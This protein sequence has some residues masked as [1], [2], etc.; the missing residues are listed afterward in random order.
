VRGVE[1]PVAE[2]LEDCL[3]RL[4]V[5]GVSGCLTRYPLWAAEL[6]PL[7]RMAARLQASAPLQMRPAARAALK[8]QV[9]ARATQARPRS[10]P[11]GLGPRLRRWLPAAPLWRVAVAFTLILALLLGTWSAA[12]ASLPGDP[13]YRLKL[14]GEGLRLW[15]AGD[16]AGQAAVHFDL[17]DRRSTEIALRTAQQRLDGLDLAVTNLRDHLTRGLVAFA[18]VL[19]AH[20]QALTTQLQQVTARAATALAGLERH[21]SADPALASVLP[22]A[23][24]AVQQAEQQLD[25]AHLTNPPPAL[26]PHPATPLPT[27]AL[28][29]APTPPGSRAVPSAPPAGTMSTPPPG[30][31]PAAGPP[32]V[33]S[34]AGGIPT[35]VG[36]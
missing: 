36:V 30:L 6:E 32:T 35:P 13:L 11:A 26:T 15:Q 5:E 1:D 17:A 2:A 25:Q 27:P 23:L 20:Q 33:T 7:L 4:P 18:A 3:A 14:A 21:I 22:P 19:P 16:A 9:L 31:S 28:S 12:A 10:A 8:E 29:A 24:A 34:V